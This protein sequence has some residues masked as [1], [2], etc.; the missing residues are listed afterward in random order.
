MNDLVTLMD[1]K[2]QILTGRIIKNK[3]VDDL[4]TFLDKKRTNI[5]E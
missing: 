5:K 2:E 3:K 1:K 4:V